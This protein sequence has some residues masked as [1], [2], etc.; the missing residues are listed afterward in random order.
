MTIEAQRSI[1]GKYGRFSDDMIRVT[2]MAAIS[3]AL[4]NAIFRVIPR[5]Y[6]DDIY[7]A[8]KSCAVGDA[9]TLVA[10]RDE[11]LAWLGKKGIG[12]ERIFARLEVAGA[13]DIGLEHLAI[14]IGIGSSLKS[15][16]LQLDDA[17]PPPVS[18]APGP[19]RAKTAALDTLVNTHKAAAPVA[20][21]PPANEVTPPTLTWPLVQAELVQADGAWQGEDRLPLIMAWTPEQMRLAYDW[22]AAFNSEVDDDKL[23]ERPAF[24][25][26]KIERQPGEDG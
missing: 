19:V 5:A 13:A 1:V 21:P 24:T 7:T 4:R 26:L 11:W 15:G 22:A 25:V 18:A 9:K 8:A 12:P 2:G 3:I 23:P 16:E 14:L 10:R 20:A 6:V 17:F